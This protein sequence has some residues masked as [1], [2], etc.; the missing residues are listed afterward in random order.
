[1]MVGPPGVPSTMS[2]RPSR[3]STIDGVIA[4]SMRLYG[5]MAL[6]SPWIRPYMFGCPGAVVKSSISLF[7][8]KPAPVH[9]ERRLR[10]RGHGDGVVRG[11]GALARRGGERRR[12]RG[13]VRQDLAAQL[14]G[15]GLGEQPLQ[16]HV[17]EVRVAEPVV[18]VHEGAAHRLDLEMDIAGAPERRQRV[19]G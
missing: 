11:L 5:A 15:V 18:A 14:G 7:S 17:D 10:Q 13:A 2:S 19:V 3:P 9:V 1:M 4:D 6:A 12:G 16:R 8:R